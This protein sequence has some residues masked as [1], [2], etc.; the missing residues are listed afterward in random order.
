M[1]VEARDPVA[2]AAFARTGADATAAYA[3]H[4]RQEDIAGLGTHSNAGMSQRLELEELASEAET[5]VERIRRL[6]DI[7][8]IVAAADGGLTRGDVIRSRV[9]SAFEAEGFSLDQMEVAIRERAVALD[10]LHL[11]YPDPSPRTG[12]TYGE[13]IAE[14]GERGELVGSVLSAMGLS[15]P[16]ADAP[17]REM[18][19]ELVRALIAGWS[20]V[21]PEFTLRAARIFGDAARRAAEGWVA[22]FGEAISEPIESNFTTLDDVVTRLLKPAASLSDLS[23]RLLAWLLERHLERGMNDLNIGRIERRLQ[24]R[25]LMPTPADHPPAVAFVDV[26]GYTRLTVDRG[27]DFSARTSVR[28]GE[29]AEMVMRRHGGRVVKLLGDG[30][31][32]VFDSPCVAVEAVAEL[33]RLMVRAGLPAVHAGIHA[34][35]IVERDGDVYGS[36]VNVAARIASHAPAGTILVSDNVVETCLEHRGRFE[37]LGAV[38]IR[39][40][41][42]PL[43]LN[44][45]RPLAVSDGS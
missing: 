24:A 5:T 10:S 15:A 29:L 3:E 27:D 26:S 30:V 36:T 13:F 32:L 20:G 11:F 34:G 23:P 28:L 7:G 21:D 18:E 12:R 39:G 4:L 14:I 37:A 31:L 45:L 40:L 22:L 35:P 16:A 33:T 25:G 1:E 6:I 8:A 41:V 19:E 17:T 2:A 44:R 43:P 42:E 38:T 9:V